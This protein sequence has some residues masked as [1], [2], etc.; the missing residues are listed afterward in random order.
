MGRT[1]NH[2]SGDTMAK[3]PTVSFSKNAIPSGGTLIAIMAEGAGIPASL[4]SNA[5]MAQLEKAIKV[6]KFTGKKGSSLSVSGVDGGLDRI[7]LIGC[8]KPDQLSEADLLKTGGKLF[9]A[10]GKAEKVFVLTEG[11]EKTG[12]LSPDQTALVAAGV[13]LRAYHFDDYVCT[14]Q[15]LLLF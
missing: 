2:N 4:A 3:L 10:A 5:A 13:K 9:A 7:I 11:E 1:L 14:P 6:E 12:A 15:Y 8:G